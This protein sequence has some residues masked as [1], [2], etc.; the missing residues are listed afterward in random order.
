MSMFMD[1]I[2]IQIEWMNKV[3]RNKKFIIREI[4]QNVR[5]TKFV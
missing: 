4:N 1:G 2:E 3:E 5:Y